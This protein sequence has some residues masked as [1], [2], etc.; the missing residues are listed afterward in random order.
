MRAPLLLLALAA[1][2]PKPT[3]G[4]V[5]GPRTKTVTETTVVPAETL[6]AADDPCQG[7]ADCTHEAVELPSA[8]PP[9]FEAVHLMTYGEDDEGLLARLV[10]RTGGTW[11]ILGYPLPV[12][13]RR[14]TEITD[15]HSTG[16]KLVVEYRA[17]KGRFD[18][19]H[20]EGIIVCKP[21]EKTLRCVGPVITVLVE[22]KHTGGKEDGTDVTTV[23]T[24]CT[25]TVEGERLILRPAEQTAFDPPAKPDRP[26]RCATDVELAF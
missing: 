10:F 25:A 13:N 1:C 7:D 4:P 21:V 14:S 3:T 22:N 12:G 5:D 9:P 19:E 6:L 24:E 2:T 15:I 26:E 8:L 11:H 17:T 16:G 20:E 23:M 18:W